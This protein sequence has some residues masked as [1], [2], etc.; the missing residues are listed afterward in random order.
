MDL[1]GSLESPEK[2]YRIGQTIFVR[3]IQIDEEKHRCIVSLKSLIYDGEISQ[4]NQSNNVLKYYLNEKYQLIENM[5]QNGSGP[6]SKFFQE[7]KQWIGLKCRYLIEKR[8]DDW[9]NGRLENGLPASLPY[10][11]HY[12][13]GDSIDCYIIDYNIPSQQFILTIDLKKS[14]KYSVDSSETFTQCIILCQLPNYALGITQ[15]SN[16]LVHLPTFSDLNSFYSISSKVFYKRKQ[17]I[18]LNSLTPYISKEYNYIIF[19]SES[20]I[21][22]YQSNEIQSVTILD[23]LSKQLNVKLN[24]GT[25]GRIHI[26]E[27]FDKP[28]PEKFQSL[29]EIYQKNQILNARIIGTRKIEK[30]SKH[31]RPVYE[32]SLRENPIKEYE[33]GER[34]VGFFDKIDEKTKG[35]W[36]YL[37]VNI[38]GYVPAEFLSKQLNL[39]QCCYLTILNKTKNDKGEYYIL[40]MF[41]NNQS[42]SNIVYAK[43][44]EIKSINEFH[45][46]ITKNNEIYQ[47]ILISTD[48]ADVFEDFIFWNYLMNVKSPLLVNGQLN[49]KKELWKFRNKTIRAFIKEE[50]QEKKQMILSTRKSRL[51]KNHLDIIDEE[52]ENIDQIT[53]GDVLHGYIENLTNR[54]ITVLIGSGR[55]ILGQVEKVFNRTL[56]GHL[57]EYLDVGMVV[58]AVVLK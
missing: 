49:I 51:D 1:H 10:D 3:I 35:Y 23:V 13:I 56:N 33:I 31:Q 9:F 2:K 11:A 29:N 37:S 45:F 7:T 43:F 25:H 54:Q 39:G 16:H 21:K 32:L 30:D 27:L 58:E 15:P 38:H 50:N 24:D 22:I 18:N 52:I 4:L 28:S 8:L 36:F 19:P 5:K 20:S 41:D 6:L 53:I 12:S 48:V 14:L 40:T 46:N 42:E 47:G 17:Q 55:T 26:T 44:Q 57:R 34:V